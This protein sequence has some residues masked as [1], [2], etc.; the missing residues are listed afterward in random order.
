MST[1]KLCLQYAS[2]PYGGACHIPVINRKPGLRQV[3][4]GSS[5]RSLTPLWIREVSFKRAVRG[6]LAQAA[7]LCQEVSILVRIPDLGWELKG[8]SAHTWTTNPSPTK[9]NS[10]I[11]TPPITSTS[12][13]INSS[14]ICL[15]RLW[16]GGS[17]CSSRSIRCCHDLTPVI[18]TKK[19]PSRF[20]TGGWF[21]SSGCAGGG[22]S[23]FSG[24]G[25]S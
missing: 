19:I 20:V 13:S 8:G 15:T 23:V 11:I 6:R 4:G 14:A 21:A 18:L 2:R 7:S 1:R 10:T 25:K 12:T 16:T 24:T 22:G 5:G 17:A 9:P 3:A